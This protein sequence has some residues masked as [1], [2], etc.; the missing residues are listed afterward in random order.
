MKIRLNEA[1]AAI[2]CLTASMA[3]ACPIGDHEQS[4]S[5]GG[6]EGFTISFS[7]VDVGG[8]HRVDMFVRNTGGAN[9]TQIKGFTATF[10]NTGSIKTYWKVDD[11]DVD[12]DGNPAP[13]GNPDTVDLFNSTNAGNTSNLRVSTTG[14]N[15]TYVGVTADGVPNAGGMIQ[16]NNPWADGTSTFGLAIANTGTTQASSGSGFRIARLFLDDVGGPMFTVAGQVGGDT[17]PA[18]PFNLTYFGY[19][20]P[21]PEIR[22]G[23]NPLVVDVARPGPHSASTS[24]SGY[25]YYNRP[26]T[27]E[28]GQIPAPLTDNFALT[29]WAGSGLGSVSL[30]NLNLSDLGIHSIPIRGTDPTLGTNITDLL[31]VRIIPEPI[32]MALMFPFV[33]L[34]RR[35]R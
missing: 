11:T 29:T 18:V 24:V 13:D 19:T 21:V 30:S 9:G 17:G 8:R 3:V 1:I 20:C 5:F 31:E 23:T 28:A 27:L 34:L 25:G 26:L 35:R 2:A 10:T 22:F 33:C 14:T 6:P 32:A 12:G 4:N 16:P 15:N 7:G